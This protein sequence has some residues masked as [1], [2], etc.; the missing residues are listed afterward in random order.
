[1]NQN[2]R[3]AGISSDET[4]G[5]GGPVINSGGLLA[6]GNQGV[7]ERDVFAFAPE[8]NFKL[9]Y[10]LHKNMLLSVGYSFIY[11]DN[12]ALTGDAVDRVV[13]DGSQLGTGTFGPRPAF[14]FGD[15][16]L[17]V[18]GLDLGVVIDF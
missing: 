16:S 7:Y 10:C 6:Q 14:A 18:Q 17:W 15:S 5:A 1:M 11:F 8:V 4:P 13:S 3:I 9:A 12:V 2:T